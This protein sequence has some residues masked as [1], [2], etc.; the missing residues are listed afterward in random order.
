M[1]DINNKIYSNNNNLL[2]GI[3]NDLQQVINSSNEN[4]VIKRISDII[5]K[6]N[7]IIIENK[8]N[9]ELIINYITN[10]Q[11]QMN[12]NFKE[13]KNNNNQVK[14]FKN[15]KYIGQV[16]NGLKEGKGIYYQNNDRYEGE[17]KNDKRKEKEF[18]I[19]KVVIDMKA[20]GELGKLKE[21]KF[22]IKKW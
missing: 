17:F 18:I 9:T 21:K 8:K 19:I 11:N 7:N 10:L 13:L 4:I 20:I 2:L 5:I 6:M 14:K 12:Q 16:I 22:I 15:G 3:V 1:N